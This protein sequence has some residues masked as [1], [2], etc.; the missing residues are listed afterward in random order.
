MDTAFCESLSAVFRRVFASQ[1]AILAGL[2]GGLDSVVLLHAL[3]Q[4]QTAERPALRL[5][6]VYIHHGLNPL[7]DDWA[8]H[9]RTF[10]DSLSVPFQVCRVQVD[11]RK[12]GIEAAARDARY[13]AFREVIAP[14]EALVTAQHLDD[15]SETFFLALKRGSGPAGLSAMPEQMAFGAN[16]LIRP[17]LSFSRAQLEQ[18]AQYYQ[19][20]W[21]E[22]DSN[23]DRRY[24]RNFLRHAVL[25]QLNARWP[26]FAQAVSRSAALCGEQEALLDELLLPE[27]MQL[28]DADNGLSFIPLLSA[29]TAKRNGILRRWLKHCGVQ[30]PSQHQLALL[31]QEVALAKPDAEPAII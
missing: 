29:R 3:R 5:R 11:P 16:P 22:D 8:D 10:C 24:D 12:K 6:A 1:Q 31:W 18:Y 19:L 4:W 30:M 2:S 17:L 15:Q 23:Q 9:C 25:P 13:Q 27:L 21:V 14:D 28:T 7:A 26:H 20:S